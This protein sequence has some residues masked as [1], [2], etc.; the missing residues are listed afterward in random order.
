MNSAQPIQ[1]LENVS[2]TQTASHTFAASATGHPDK[3]A[4]EQISIYYG[5]AQAVANAS[6]ALAEGEIGC[7]LGP[8][9]CG[10]STLLRAI[11]GLESV[12]AGTLRVDDIV[13]SSPTAL[14][15][16]EQRNIG[17]VFQ[18][19]ALFPH[20]SIADNIRFGIRNLPR[21][22]QEQRI[23]ELLAL[24]GLPDI[25]KRYPG[26]LSG[27]QQQR[28]A[29]AR[30]LAPRPS[31]L[32]L[33]E[34]FSGLDARLRENLVPEVREIL[35]QLQISALMVSHD[36]AEAFALAD[37][38]GV[39]NQGHILQWDTPH[40]IYNHP[41]HRFCAAFIGNGEFLRARAGLT[42][43]DTALG[44]IPYDTSHSVTAG[45]SLE[46][47]LRLNNLTID[48]TSPYKAKITSKT[49]CGAYTLYRLQLNS[50]EQL[51]CSCPSEQH[52]NLGE[53][54][55]IRLQLKQLQLFSAKSL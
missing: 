39:M 16:P 35:K 42:Q 27:G 33:D 52:F 3:L 24:V 25:Q 29:L 50:G 6:L 17:M 21:K 37:K 13:L 9:G 48:N 20:L 30:A 19:I 23:S 12:Q 26:S 8:S 7:L 34:P 15:P 28:I 22:E 45:D 36:Q 31:I 18:D 10:K 55:G 43:L 14:L 44:P 2:L 1:P 4:L 5:T 51:H 41:A 54:V 46:L 49:F 47:L 40:A 32:L 11:A 38:I 53:Q